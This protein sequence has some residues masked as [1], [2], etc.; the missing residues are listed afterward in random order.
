MSKK[1]FLMSSLCSVHFQHGP[2]S[3]VS[4]DI[5]ET[6]TI[7]YFSV[8]NILLNLYINMYYIHINTY[9][10]LAYIMCYIDL[11]YTCVQQM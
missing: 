3:I 4:R 8:S 2:D 11:L 5:G 7:H 1:V 9:N 6:L 10:I